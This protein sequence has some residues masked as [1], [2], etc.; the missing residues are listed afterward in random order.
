MAV[1]PFWAGTRGLSD[2]GIAKEC[3]PELISWGLLMS[4]D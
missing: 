4:Y 3:E 1:E 2:T